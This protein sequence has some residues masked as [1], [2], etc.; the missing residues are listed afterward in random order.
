MAASPEEDRFLLD[1]IAAAL[2]AGRTILRI[3]EEDFQVENKA[4]NSPVTLADLEAQ[5]VIFPFLN[6]S[7]LPVISEEAE[8]PAFEVRKSWERFWL[9]DPLDGTK[10]FI[11]RN[12]EF[13]VNIALIRH[14]KPEMGIVLSPATDELYA[15]WVGQG[16]WHVTSASRHEFLKMEDLAGFRLPID[17][18]VA[19]PYTVAVSRSHSD[20][21]TESY[22][23]RLRKEK[24]TLQVLP[25]GS[26]MK[27]CL[28]AAGKADEYPRFGPTREWDTAAGHAVMLAAGKDVL[29]MTAGTTLSYNQHDL[30]HGAFLAR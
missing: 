21:D 25:A 1:A 18:P 12:G 28:V 4:D 19:R 27:F 16:I 7:R 17:V 26:S 6:A 8:L 23:L 10:E 24:G 15:G 29:H 3:Y 11:H 9:V 14:G 30:R 13:T 22:L 5:K 2:A 20:A